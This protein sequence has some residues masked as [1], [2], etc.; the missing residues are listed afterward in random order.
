M[1][2]A[3]FGIPA[4]R[5]MVLLQTDQVTGGA[6]QSTPEARHYLMQAVAH[7]GR[8][9]PVLV[10]VGGISGTGKTVLARDL[11]PG[12]GSC[13]GAVHLRTD[14]E[15]KQPAGKVDYAPTSRGVV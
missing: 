13:P 6:G 2:P 14:T 4:I 11:A 12:I 15:R 3:G 8:Q 1:Q 9:S 7:L 10:A 5:A